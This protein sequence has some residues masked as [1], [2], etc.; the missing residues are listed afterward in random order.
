MMGDTGALAT[1]SAPLPAGSSVDLRVVLPVLLVGSAVE[2]H[3][4]DSEVK[5]PLPLVPSGG[6]GFATGHAW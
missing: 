6:G 3:I 2:S 1:M 4:A 5:S